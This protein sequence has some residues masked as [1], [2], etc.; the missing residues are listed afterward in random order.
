[1]RYVRLILLTLLATQLSL[2]AQEKIYSIEGIV[3]DKFTGNGLSY[4]SVQ[5]PEIQKGD[6]S[7]TTGYYK[8]EH[9]KTG[10]YTLVFTLIGYKEFSRK[11]YIGR[12]VTY[13]VSLEEQ[14]LLFEPIEITPGVIE[15]SSDGGTA[16]SVT[17]EEITTTATLFSKDVYRSLQVLPGVSN[18]EW[19]S[20]P[21][22]K[23]GN[24]D[25]TSI[26]IDNFEI[27][28]PFHLEEIDGPFSIISSDLVKDMKLITGGFSAKYSDK[29]SG[30]LK[31]KTIDRVDNDYLKGSIDFM[32]ASVGLNQQISNRV[33]NFFSGR[34]TYTYFIEKATETNFPSTVY[35]IWNKL[36]YKVDKRNTLSFNTIFLSD[37]I[38]YDQD[39]SFISRE[40]FD[41]YKKNL[42][43]WINWQNVSSENRFFVTTLG[44]Q[45]LSKKSDFSFDGSFSNNNIDKRSTQIITLKQDHY[46]K[47][48]DRHAIE[49]GFEVNKF[50]TNYYYQEFRINPTE[51]S[52][53]AVSTDV[54]F[55]DT[56]FDGH[57][58]AAYLQDTWTI[59]DKLNIL[60]GWRVSQQS[61]S[62]YV[63][64]APRIAFSYAF[65]DN[66]NAKLAYGWYYQP[67]SFYKMRTYQ[68][69][70]K[71]DGKPEKS[72]HYVGSLAYAYN[73]K[74][75]MTLDL[76][77]KDY[78]HL[79]DDYRFDFFNRIEGIG[80]ID[81]PYYTKKGYSAGTDFFV[82]IRY[83]RSNLFSLS[84]SL[85]FSRITNYLNQTTARDI[86][87]THVLTLN[88][89]INFSR[90]FT[91]STLL[92]YHTGDPYTPS[93]V[94]IIGDSAV[95]NSKIFYLT[96]TKNSKRLPIF[97]S[98]DIKLEKKWYV[99]QMSFITY[100][101]IINALNHKNIRQYGWKRHIENERLTGFSIDEQVYFPRFFSIGLALELDIPLS[102][103]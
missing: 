28:E 24:P 47:L 55:V 25:E 81:K 95:E 50:F 23:G 77:Y 65:A 48:R 90:Q 61:Y 49:A 14:S 68:N 89:V 88:N 98:L 69:Q 64:L 8:I 6:I 94:R 91:L 57:T 76:Y 96:D 71:L 63:Q 34:R 16:S 70:S 85:A 33:N 46:W 86:D 19:S 1:M 59:T 41:S 35:D 62:D 87:R 60:G 84:Y 52:D 38:A 12:N 29:M 72:V 2:T 51:T 54:I 26:L 79:S 21:Y 42:Y 40:F 102:P 31:A 5:I 73:E 78:Q 15:L 97:Y 10:T 67:D 66:L 101:N 13:N 43:G 4:V 56:D 82:R 7:D 45:Q 74:T 20:K 93:L 39:S 37:R 32:N 100:A 3:K 99:D 53:I 18:S 80:I 9:I 83:G 22:I 75:D 36:D 17:S 58:L 11:I 44:F 30:I 92:R 103:K 27:Y